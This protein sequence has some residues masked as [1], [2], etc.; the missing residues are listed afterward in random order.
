MNGPKYLLDTNIILYIL[1]GNETLANHLHKKSLYTSFV[2]EIELFSFSRL[3]T[4]EEKSIRQFLSQFRII[5]ID[6]SIKQEAISLR[7][8]YA[9]KLPDCI[10]AATAITLQLTL[11]TADK[12]YRQIENLPLEL[13]E[14]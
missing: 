10:I 3:T 2:S 12:Q 11:I 8:T 6:Q 5:D 13:V 9:L 4:K 7:K 1:A 14:F